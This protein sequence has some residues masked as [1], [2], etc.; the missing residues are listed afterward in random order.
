MT[1]RAGSSNVQIILRDAKLLVAV[2]AVVV[3]VL[4]EG[5]W[6]AI[7]GG[8]SDIPTLEMRNPY[9]RSDSRSHDRY[10]KL[11]DT[12]QNENKNKNNNKNKQRH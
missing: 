4:V 2:V 12:Q 3:V 9:L 6:I 1:W 8:L 7:D 10:R 5:L 11:L